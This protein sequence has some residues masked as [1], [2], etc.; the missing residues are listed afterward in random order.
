MG[1]MALQ[2]MGA[3]PERSLSVHLPNKVNLLQDVTIIF[4]IVSEQQE[5]TIDIGPS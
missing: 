1:S 2:M 4:A 5:G 3:C